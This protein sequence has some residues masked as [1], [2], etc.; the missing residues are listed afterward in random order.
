MRAGDDDILVNDGRRGEPETGVLQPVERAGLHIHD[1]FVAEAGNRL[2]GLGVQ[3]EQL[4]A[5]S[6]EED[7]RG[8]ILVAG[9][10]FQTAHG[11][12]AILHVVGPDFLGGLRFQRDDAVVRRGQVHDAFDD[13]RRDRPV[14]SSAAAPAA[15]ASSAA[16]GQAA[17]RRAAP[18]VAAGIHVIGPGADQLG[19][20]LRV[21]LL[22]RRVARA[23]QVVAEGRPIGLGK[24][25]P[26]KSGAELLRSEVIRISFSIP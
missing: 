13:Q 24:C 21:D 10:V 19:H 15:A 17:A 4:A 18:A 12:C 7:R 3:R 9:P 22:Q 26:G 23:C 20:I 6:A 1:A 11:G 8:R 25:G 14:A 5:G 2:A 16:F